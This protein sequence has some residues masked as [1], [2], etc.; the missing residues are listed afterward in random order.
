M[1]IIVELSCEGDWDKDSTT[2]LWDW[3]EEQ[4]SIDNQATGKNVTVEDIRVED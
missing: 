1:K 2:C 4:L 3:L